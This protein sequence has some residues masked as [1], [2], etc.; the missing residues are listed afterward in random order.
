M[1]NNNFNGNRNNYKNGNGSN[2]NYSYAPYNFIPLSKRVIKRYEDIKDLP[3]H[4]EFVEGT[5]SGEIEYTIENITDLIISDGNSKF[6]RDVNGNFAIPGSTLRGKLRSNINILGF[7]AVGED[8]QDERFLYRRFASKSS[9]LNKEYNNRL[10]MKIERVNGKTFSTLQNVNSGYVKKINDEEYVIIKSKEIKGKT[11]FRISEEDLANKYNG[12][13]GINFMNDRRKTKSYEPYTKEISFEINDNNKGIKSIGPKDKLKNNGYL[14]SS[15][16]IYGKKSHYIINEIDDD[17][18]IIKLSPDDIRIYKKYYIKDKKVK[19]NS[20]GFYSL[21]EDKNELKPVFY[22]RY[23]GKIYFG[24][25]QYLRMFY[26][27]SIH[28]GIPSV[29]KEN[30][31]DYKKAIFGFT[32]GNKGYKSRISV[33][34]A[35][36]V[37]NVKTTKHTMVLGEPKATCVQLYLSQD[38]DR[39]SLHSYNGEFEIRGIKYY[40]LKEFV[41]PEEAKGNVNSV[42]EAVAKGTKFKGKIKFKNLNED[43]LGLLVWALYIHKDA[44]Q[45]IGKGK[46][47][48][49]GN[50][51]IKDI[52]IKVDNTEE[53]YND[54]FANY[55]TKLNVEECIDKYK[56]YAKSYLN[57]ISSIEEDLAVRTFIEVHKNTNRVEPVSYM[58][59]KKINPNTNRAYNEFAAYNP[60]SQPLEVLGVTKKKLTNIQTGK[61]NKNN[62]NKDKSYS[63]NNNYNK[64]N[65]RSK[66]VS[67]HDDGDLI[68][69]P[70]AAALKNYK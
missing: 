23:N 66:N 5:L 56:N 10:G 21:P 32:N 9:N 69:N 11:Y 52:V 1:R 26:D 16:S 68:N 24:F 12:M 2:N 44:N 8:I 61:E 20:N 49:F 25:T 38:G 51:K 4:N 55:T 18:E 19:L 30:V 28:D 3:G 39:D 50:I 35:I 65:H 70:F 67:I 33:E 59:I 46:P 63:K 31:L 41:K 13:S 40:W 36:A 27:K 48:G 17:G 47:Y 53:K 62:Q 14:L 34:D 22:V 43:E 45:N 15:G 58:S 64:N 6:F 7:S 29:H 54:I 42:E 57:N 60:L 37:G